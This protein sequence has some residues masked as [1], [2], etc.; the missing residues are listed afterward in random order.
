MDEVGSP[1]H[2]KKGGTKILFLL[3]VFIVPAFS[4]PLFFFL[5]GENRN[6][7]YSAR[8]EAQLA[9]LRLSDAMR[10][11]EAPESAVQETVKAFAVYD[12]TG[13]ALRA[14][15]E[16]PASVRPDDFATGENAS[17]SALGGGRYSLLLRMDAVRGNM[18]M[19]HPSD[20]LLGDDL[21]RPLPPAAGKPVPI[22]YFYVETVMPDVSRRQSFL[23]LSAVMFLLLL[24]LLLGSLY[25]ALRR[26][27]RYLERLEERERLARLGEAARL[28]S[29]EIKN[30]L[31][32]IR[33]RT[34]ILRRFVP[35]EGMEDLF[36]IRSETDRLRDL[37]DRVGEFLRDP[38]GNPED[39]DIVKFLSAWC[40][41][42]VPRAEFRGEGT[43]LTA[44]DRGR[45]LS[46]LDNL[47]ANASE[48][49]SPSLEVEVH[50]DAK[51]LRVLLLDRGG[52]LS[53]AVS[54]RL[55]EPFFT[56]KNTGSGI[57][58]STAR[59]FVEAAGGTLT[60]ANR[61]GGGAVAE[62]VLA[63]KAES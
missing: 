22:R 24:A 16:V 13:T 58:L 52:G 3:L 7:G 53:D 37:T 49:G 10:R 38:R 26:N 56:T 20:P 36:I 29:H 45:L 46:V 41:A 25:A 31:A 2:G 60:L 18:R 63:R 42:R 5:S 50:A 55:F 44:I 8:Y 27:E 62:I 51:R 4:L 54:A 35:P 43:V 40:D 59:R 23:L 14:W 61:Q 12:Q 28:L 34:D 1:R 17:F 11:G 39:L 30:P 21:L 19:R 9:A 6:I 47:A 33:L 48:A 32:A 57:G 15:G